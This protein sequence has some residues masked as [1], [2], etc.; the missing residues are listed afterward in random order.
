MKVV[1]HD[2]FYQVY[3]TDPASAAGRM[4]AIVAEIEND[5]EFVNAVPAGQ[6]DIARVHERTHI[7]SVRHARGQ[8]LSH[9]PEPP[10]QIQHRFQSPP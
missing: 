10:S 4:E 5:V 7:D 9:R 8:C 3:T 6:N 2:D 1:F